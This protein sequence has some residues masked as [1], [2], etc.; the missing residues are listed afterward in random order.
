MIKYDLATMK[1]LK[2]RTNSVNGNMG[3]SDT[4]TYFDLRLCF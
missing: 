3:N 4:V 1:S 2:D